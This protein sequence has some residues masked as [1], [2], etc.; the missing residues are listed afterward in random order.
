MIPAGEA[1]HRASIVDDDPLRAGREARELL[2]GIAEAPRP[3]H[4]RRSTS[5]SSKPL[6]PSTRAARSP[7]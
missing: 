6:V 7:T 3:T 1:D 4:E 5:P 2:A